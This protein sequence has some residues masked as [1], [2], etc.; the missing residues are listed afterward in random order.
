MWNP[1]GAWD[2]H[3]VRGEA[4]KMVVRGKSGSSASGEKLKRQ[5]WNF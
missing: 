3:E 4:Q 2:R 1:T 5:V